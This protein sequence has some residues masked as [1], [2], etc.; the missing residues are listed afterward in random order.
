MNTREVLQD[1]ISKP[2][3]PFTVMGL[4]EELAP[5]LLAVPTENPQKIVCQFLYSKLKEL[6]SS[7]NI[8]LLQEIS[9]AIKKASL[10]KS[11]SEE[12]FKLTPN[13][14]PEEAADFCTRIHQELQKAQTQKEELIHF[15]SFFVQAKGYVNSFATASEI[16]LKDYFEGRKELKAQKD[17]LLNDL[18]SYRVYLNSLAKEVNQ[19]LE[20]V[21]SP[22]MN[23]FL[24]ME[25]SLRLVERYRDPT[26]RGFTIQT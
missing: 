13:P 26:M 19:I 10:E 9:T 20:E 12:S 14:T 16:I 7:L 18:E 24:R 5:L 22:R 23:L 25:S 3:T 17:S 2:N 6:V 15:S 11:F 4:R 8:P 1:L 21:M